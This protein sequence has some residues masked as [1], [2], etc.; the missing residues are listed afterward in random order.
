MLRFSANLSFMFTE[1]EFLERFGRASKAGFT[2]VEC[3]FPYQWQKEALAETLEKLNLEM[4]VQS[5][6]AGDWDAGERGLA[7]IPGREGEFQEGVG[8]A[9]EYARA[10]NCA[11]I[12]CL[13]GLTPK[14]VPAENVPI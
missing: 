13:A 3:V 12:N 14:D 5:M 7:C 2:A 4:V 9:I 8:V 10:M 6:P 1:V 11:R